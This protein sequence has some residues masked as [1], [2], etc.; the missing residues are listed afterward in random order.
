M[1]WCQGRTC[2]PAVAALTARACGRDVTAVD[3]LALARRPIGTPVRLAE[4]A[5]VD[6]VSRVGDGR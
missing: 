5:D 1:G 6:G 4:L 2:G 3:L